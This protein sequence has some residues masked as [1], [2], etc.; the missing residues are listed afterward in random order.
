MG[1]PPPPA[2]YFLHTEM[3]LSVL[4]V[5]LVFLVL[6]HELLVNVVKMTLQIINQLNCHLDLNVT[7]NLSTKKRILT[8]QWQIKVSKII[9]VCRVLHVITLVTKTDK[10]MKPIGTV[11][12]LSRPLPSLDSHAYHQ[13][14]C[15]DW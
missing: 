7:A 10:N 11:P 4:I 3:T 5:L 1:S 6:Y 12:S 14:A 13:P 2:I 9:I 8:Q 15:T